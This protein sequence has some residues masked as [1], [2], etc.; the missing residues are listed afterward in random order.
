MCVRSHLFKLGYMIRSCLLSHFV[1][2]YVSFFPFS[3]MLFRFA[4]QGRALF[5]E[6]CMYRRIWHAV[7]MCRQSK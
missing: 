2:L 5:L 4:L 1:S 6:I 3:V 7:I